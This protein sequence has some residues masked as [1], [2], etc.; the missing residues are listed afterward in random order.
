MVDVG[1][2]LEPRDEAYCR[3]LGRY[4]FAAGHDAEDLAQEARIAA[5]LAP[6]HR[7]IAARRQVLDVLKSAQRRP[8]AAP[9]PE[10]LAAEG[11]LFELVDTRA[12]LRALRSALPRLSAR[13]RG[14]LA[15]VTFGGETPYSKS[16][17]TAARRARRKL[18][19]ATAPLPMPATGGHGDGRNDDGRRGQGA[20][21]VGASP[22]RRP[23][24][25]QHL[26]VGELRG[27]EHAVEGS[28]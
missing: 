4:F 28:A 13:E 17:E 6:N 18:R 14:A 9:L 7:R 27:G 5:W 15:R 3:W 8:T 2:P 10:G 23:Q 21:S 1:T 22:P 26:M 11:D 19:T 12:R 20:G 25:A 24:L 16:V